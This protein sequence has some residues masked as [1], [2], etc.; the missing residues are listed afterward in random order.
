MSNERDPLLERW[1]DSADDIPVDEAYTDAVMARV[2]AHRR[3]IIGIR[4][5]ILALVV[6]LELL[7]DSPLAS[8]VGLLSNALGTNIYPVENEWVGFIV[9]PINSVAGIAGLML[10]LLHAF[11]RRFR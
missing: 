4:F 2:V 10:L 9:S 3:R 8:S 7:L 6:A 11:Y 5:G 1:F